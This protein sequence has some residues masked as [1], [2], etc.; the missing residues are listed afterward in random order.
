MAAKH[1][2]ERGMSETRR[3][4]DSQ[5]RR[6]MQELGLR[7]AQEMRKEPAFHYTERSVTPW[8]QIDPTPGSCTW[9]TIEIAEDED[10][11][12][13]VGSEWMA[14]MDDIGR[15]EDANRHAMISFYPARRSRA[16]TQE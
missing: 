16:A 14:R 4:E 6:E 10:R 9:M 15:Y 3:G 12:V 11:A 1:K 7:V 5:T 2:G 13:L 8:E